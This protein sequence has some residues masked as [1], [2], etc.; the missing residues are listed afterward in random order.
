MNSVIMAL[1][2]LLL[3]RGPAD[4]TPLGL[5]CYHQLGFKCLLNILAISLISA[6]IVLMSWGSVLDSRILAFETIPR[7]LHDSTF[8]RSSQPSRVLLKTLVSRGQRRSGSSQ[9][10]LD[11]IAAPQ[12]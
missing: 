1:Q 2:I 9:I 12:F 8:S 3:D 5:Q 4:G 10:L 11:R 7:Y 6:H